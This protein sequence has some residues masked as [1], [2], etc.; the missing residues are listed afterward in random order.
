MS[1]STIQHEF[2][3]ALGF[4]HEQQRP[5]LADHIDIHPKKFSCKGTLKKNANYQCL[6]CSLNSLG[7]SNYVWK[8]LN[9]KIVFTELLEFATFISAFVSLLRKSKKSEYRPLVTL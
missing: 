7:K 9:F 8:G 1:D 3:H 6:G 2:Y 5:D 4:W